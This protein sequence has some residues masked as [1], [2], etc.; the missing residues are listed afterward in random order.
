MS[1]RGKEKILEDQLPLYN[2]DLVHSKSSGSVWKPSSLKESKYLSKILWKTGLSEIDIMILGSIGLSW[3]VLVHFCERTHVKYVMGKC[4]WKNWEKWAKDGHDPHRIALVADPQLVD[5]NSY[6]ERPDLVNAL[7][8]KISDNYLHRNYRFLQHQIDP[9]AIVFLGDLFDGG[10]EWNDKMWFQEYQRFNDI[11]PSQP[12]RRTI[13]SIPGNHD[14]GFEIIDPH[15]LK[16]FVAFFGPN[17]DFVEFGNHSIVLLDD[18]SLSSEFPEVRKPAEEYLD[19]INDL[20][21]PNFPRVLMTHV[22]LFRDNMKQVCGPKRESSN[23]FPVQKGKQYQTVIASELTSKILET[24]HPSLV[25]A[26]DD[27]DYCEITHNLEDGSSAT[28]ITVKAVSMTAGIKHPALQLLSLHN[29]VDSYGKSLNSGPTYQTEMCY[30]P[31]P[32]FGITLYIIWLVICI[33]GLGVYFLAPNVVQKVILKF[34]SS[35]QLPVF[36]TVKDRTVSFGKRSIPKF[37]ASALMVSFY[38]FLTIGF[39]YRNV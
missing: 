30:L 34:S 35:K 6:P 31:S 25:F 21:N 20:M 8:T 27:H 19:S 23:P 18:I 4:R 15:K 22:P 16:R 2:E 1:Y 26:G 11:F 36:N 17:N 9:D 38:A 12:N 10:R 29:P 32:F 37:I 3:I 39:Y 14:I 5:G 24:I 28:E 13:Q 33:V 7:V